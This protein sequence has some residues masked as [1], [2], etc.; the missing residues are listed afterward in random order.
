MPPIG[1]RDKA[2]SFVG[3]SALNRLKAGGGARY[4]PHR[5]VPLVVRHALIFGHGHGFTA[6]NR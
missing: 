1:L 6:R 5:A 2:I 4:G 3:R